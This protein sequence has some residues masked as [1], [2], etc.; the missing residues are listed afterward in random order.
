[1]KYSTAVTTSRRKNRKAHFDSHSTR[2]QVLMSAPLSQELRNK[3]NIKSLPLRVEDE[4]KIV[5]GKAKGREGK[6]LNVARNKFCIHG[7]RVIREKAN[8]GQVPIGIDA[9]NVVITKI[10]MDKDRKKVVDRK[11]RSQGEKAKVGENMAGVD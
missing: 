8:G 2:R 1:M 11:C 4:V 5:R 6:I 10:K 3:Y 9:S 7:E